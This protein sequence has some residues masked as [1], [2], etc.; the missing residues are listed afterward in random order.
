MF[1][2]GDTSGKRGYSVG[3]TDAL[4]RQLFTEMASGVRM[5]IFDANR[6]GIAATI[7]LASKSYAFERFN[8]CIGDL[9]GILLKFDIASPKN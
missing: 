7:N 6:R 9:F 1:F 5:I 2:L 4:I 3:V 8:T